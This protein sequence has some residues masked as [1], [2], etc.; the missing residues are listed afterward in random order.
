ME[1]LMQK[2]LANFFYWLL[3]KTAESYY[4][5]SIKTEEVPYSYY[6]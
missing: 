5:D 1:I 2:T 6:F 3:M 4:G